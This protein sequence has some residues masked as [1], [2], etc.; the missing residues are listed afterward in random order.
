MQITEKSNNSKA[1]QTLRRYFLIGFGLTILNF[2]YVMVTVPHGIIN[3][4]VTSFSMILSRLPLTEV[5]PVNAWVTI[6]TGI[7]A[8]LCCIFLGRDIFIASLYSCVVGVA[9]FN[10]FTL[11]IPDSI[12]DT[13]VRLGQIGGIGASVAPDGAPIITAGLIVEL[14]AA[15]V[16]VGAGYYFCLS[17]DSTAVGMDTIA[18]ILHKRNEKI[19]IAYALYAINILVLLLG[20]YAYGLR[21]VL[22]GIAFAGVQALTLHTMLKCRDRRN[23]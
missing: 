4:G 23:K 22:M 6:V 13:M 10:F 18:L 11:V 15:A 3:G 1:A 8:L 2:A 16:V 14:I 19:P 12:I 21:C 7:L 9:A 17:N 20:L 5:L